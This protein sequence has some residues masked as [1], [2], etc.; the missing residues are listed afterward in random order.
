MSKIFRHVE[1]L[2]LRADQLK[3]L[4]LPGRF[5]SGWY[6]VTEGGSTPM[7]KSLDPGYDGPFPT[8]SEALGDEK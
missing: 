1:V 2:Y 7:G 6:R 4:G 3:R 5:E 8:Q